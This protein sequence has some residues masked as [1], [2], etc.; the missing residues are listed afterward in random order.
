MKV[1]IIIDSTVD[2]PEQHRDRFRVVPLTVRFG[3]EEFIDGVTMDRRT[4]YTRLAQSG[5]LPT[6]AQPSPA[7][8]AEAFDEVTRAGGSAVV[9]TIASRLSGTY[10]SARIAAE[11]YENIFVV[12]SQS[13]AVGSGI[14]AEYA[15]A[16]AARGM[17]ARTL[18]EH[19]R[20]RSAD[21][22]VIALLDTLEFLKRGGRISPAI[23]FAGGVLN[24]KPVI[25]I[26]DGE[27]SLIGKA[28]GAGRGSELLKEKI[29][30]SGG[31]DFSLPVLLGYSGT[32]DE[33]LNKYVME[34]RAS[35]E[36][37]G[38]PPDAALLCSVIGTHTGPG[39]VG[40]AYFRKK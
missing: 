18:A 27:V 12:D 39:V 32:S 3:A 17:D 5:E 7:L 11:G 16:C 37:H 40:V 9:I 31:A 22:R 2:V 8:F 4:F 14:L 30:E 10:Q 15:F 21:I 29:Y 36:E 34:N 23:A 1:Q 35:W 26:R 38:Q 28:R 24:V 13:A 25:G 33:L 6:S 19:L 20:E